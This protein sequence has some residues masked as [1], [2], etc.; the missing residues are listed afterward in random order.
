MRSSNS[1]VISRR[2][3]SV[4][5]AHERIWMPSAASA[6]RTS[7]AKTRAWSATSSWM[8]AR[9]CSC[10]SRG[11]IPD[12]PGSATPAA[13]R[14]FRPATRTMKYSSRFELKIARNLVR[15]NS[16]TRL[17]SFARSSTRLLNASQDSS[18]SK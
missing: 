12:A 8:R 6:G 13:M 9:I 7:S 10:R 2:S 3:L 15:S 1:V 5:S 4:S 14:R 17:A 11:R 18:R 16:G